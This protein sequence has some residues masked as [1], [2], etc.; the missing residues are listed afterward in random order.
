[1]KKS[2]RRGLIL[3]GIALLTALVSA[4]TAVGPPTSQAP[5]ASSTPT[6]CSTTV[7]NPEVAFFFGTTTIYS[8]VKN[9]PGLVSQA[10][11]A[12]T[13]SYWYAVVDVSGSASG[14]N[15]KSYPS[16]HSRVN[17]PVGTLKSAVATY[18]Y[19]LPGQGQYDFA[20]DAWLNGKQNAPGATQVQVWPGNFGRTPDGNLV[21]TYG[22]GPGY[23]VYVEPYQITFVAN[24][25]SDSGTLDLAPFLHLVTE[26]QYHWAP[27]NSTLSEVDFGP[28]IAT[29]A[30]GPVQYTV[31]KYSIQV[32]G[33]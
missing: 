20:F 9:V 17:Q 22:I 5:Q 13:T 21:G 4:C 12:C 30:G 16:V 28:Q 24:Q 7:T 10:I 14:N 2:R 31:T 8:D 11:S 27:A 29:T 26:P 25:V 23:K 15:V 6:K 19:S 33:P 32:S 3:G 18:G 1:M